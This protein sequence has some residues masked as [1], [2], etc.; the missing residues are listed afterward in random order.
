MILLKL[1]WIYL[2][3]H[4]VKYLVEQGADVHAYNELATIWSA[5]KGQVE[6]VKFLAGN[7]ADI[8]ER[9]EYALRCA[10]NSGHVDVVKYLVEQGANIHAM[11]DEALKSAAYYGHMEIVEFLLEKGAPIAVAKKRG[12]DAVKDFCKAYELRRKLDNKL[13]SASSMKNKPHKLKI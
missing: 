1:K 7:G 11:E 10:A 3:E 8:H 12:T 4:I 6:V 5:S 2:E 9:D 13:R